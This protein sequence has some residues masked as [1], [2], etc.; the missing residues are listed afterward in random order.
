MPWYQIT[1]EGSYFDISTNLQRPLKKSSSPEYNDL[2]AQSVL[3]L[4]PSTASFEREAYN[5]LALL[6][7]LGGVLEVIMLFIGFFV[8]PLSAHSF[9]QESAR[10]LFFARTSQEDLFVPVEEDDDIEDKL[11]KQFDRSSKN[12]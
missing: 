6:G 12:H 5:S 10:K 1:Y 2:L 3:F 4:E 8:R 11:A 9:I 7:D